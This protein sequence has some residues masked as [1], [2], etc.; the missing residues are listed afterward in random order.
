M[1]ACYVVMVSTRTKVTAVTTRCMAC[2][3]TM[4]RGTRH[5]GA[6]QPTAAVPGSQ[7]TELCNKSQGQ[8]QVVVGAT[9]LVRYA[10]SFW[11]ELG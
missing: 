2:M 6:P 3:H 7:R 10:H 8:E 4:R 11:P 5:R 9:P 1:I